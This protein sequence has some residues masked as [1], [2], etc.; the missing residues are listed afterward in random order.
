MKAE[1]LKLE[2]EIRVIAPSRSMGILKEEIVEAAKLRLEQEGF[3]VSFGKHVKDMV[4]EDYKCASIEARIEDLKD[5]FLNKEVK[6]ILTVIGGCNVNQ[7]LDDIPYEVIK[8]NP[9]ILCGFS[10]ITALTNSIYAKT[11]LITYSGPHFSTFAMKDGLDYTI[12]YFKQMLMEDKEVEIYASSKWS[13]DPWFKNQNDRHWVTN[14][15][16]EILQEGET[17]GKI[18]GGNLCTLNLLQ[19]T[20]FMP[21]LENS[22]LFLEDD[23]LV[24]ENFLTEFDRNLQ[25]LLHSAKGKTIRGIVFRKSTKK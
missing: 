2:D 24:Q 5:A 6:A 17:E 25:S 13:D 1:K 10:D 7:I 23:D 14:T 12:S 15:G 8:K 20:E 22:I 19:G 21:N 4:D 3:K 16:M 11:G 18:I 9:K